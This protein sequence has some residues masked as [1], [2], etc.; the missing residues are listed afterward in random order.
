MELTIIS[1]KGGTG[2]TVLAVGLASLCCNSVKADCDV[3]AP[4]LY[5]YYRG[6]DI[7]KQS[8]YAVKKAMIES[9]FCTHCG[10]C[11]SICRFGAIHDCMIDT[12]NCEGCG[13][14]ALVCPQKAISLV[15]EKSADIYLTKT[16][17]GMLSR[18]GMTAGSDGSGKLITELRKN[19]RKFSED[20][21]IQINDGSPG[22][23]C[24][25]ISSITA[26][27]LVVLVAEPTL[28][29]LNDLKR[30]AKLCRHFGIQ[31]VVCI[32]KSDI[33]KKIAEEIK[34][35]C[36]E[37]GLP[38]VGEIPFDDTV[39]QSINELKP[40][41]CY[42]DS[43]ACTAILKIWEKLKKIIDM[44]QKKEKNWKMAP[45]PFNKAKD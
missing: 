9:S 21:N 43:A 11:E 40:I 42:A 17:D 27:D 16:P 23:G 41:T 25:V 36:L 8:F 28:S 33:N 34:C 32:N 20:G 45:T 10:R 5:L 15:P 14:C 39:M 3:D 1:G 26:T 6:N 13:A 31:T 29:G 37:Q 12:A 2:K 7:K 22:I 18:A 30:V 19:A 4:N 35:Y 44:M 24:P 38:V